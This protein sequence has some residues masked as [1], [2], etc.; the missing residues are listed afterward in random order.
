MFPIAGQTSTLGPP[1]TST[2][3]TR[4]LISGRHIVDAVIGD[5]SAHHGLQKADALLSTGLSGGGIAVNN[6]ADSV[7]EM[8]PA[9]KLVALPVAANQMD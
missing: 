1:D 8:V 4:C 5:L 9:T 6:L 3:R 2:S 7:Q